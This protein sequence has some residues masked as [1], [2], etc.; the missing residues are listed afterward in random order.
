MSRR[1]DPEDMGNSIGSLPSLNHIP[2]SRSTDSGRRPRVE[3][4]TSV[5][6]S[7]HED[8]LYTVQYALSLVN[9]IYMRSMR[10]A[11][12]IY[13]L[14]NIQTDSVGSAYSGFDTTGCGQM[15]DM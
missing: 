8:S 3:V 7:I 1:R 11:V 15:S 13:I 12:G 5:H 4:L 9:P 2:S 14:F 6:V 10:T